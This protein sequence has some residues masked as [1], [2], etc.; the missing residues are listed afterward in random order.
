MSVLT[1]R[2]EGDIAIA[3]LDN[4][5]VNALSLEVR[6]A[7]WD[8]VEELDADPGV[9]A[10]I[11]ACAGR[12]FIAGADVKEFGKPP[13]P[14]HLPDLVARIEA[15][16]TPWIAAIHGSALGGGLEIAMGCRFRIAH[17]SA[18]VG[19]PEVNLGIIP[20][21]S[22]TVRTPRLM[23]AKAAVELVT[24]GRPISA[25]KAEKA[26]LVDA[27]VAGDLEE[28]ALVFAR[29]ALE[30]PLPPRTSERQVEPQPD[31]FWQDAAKT[32]SKAGHQA[33]VRAV[34]CLRRATEASFDEAMAHERETFLELRSAPEAA[35]L[36]HV[37]FAERAAPRPAHLKGVEPSDIASAGVVGG[38]TMG[39]GIAT[40]LGL[41]GLPVTVMETSDEGAERAKTRILGNF[42]G[43]LKR[44]KIDAAERERLGDAL[45]VTTD[46]SDLSS[47]DLVVEAVFE[48]LEVKRDVFARLAAAC[49]D[50]TILATNT[51]YLDPRE[52]FAGL[53]GQGRCIGLHFFSPAHVMKLVEIVP[54]PGTTPETEA[55]AFKLCARLG[56]MPVRAGICDGFIGNR[57]LKRYRAEAE[58]L[59]E[60]GV[61][62]AE[63]D[64][65]MRGFG[66]KMGPFEAQDLGGLDIAAAQRNAAREAGEDVPETLGDLLV[67]AGRK[68]QKS[69]GG[70]YDYAEGDRTPQPSGKVSE[71]LSSRVRGTSDL[72]REDIAARL[73]D[74]MAR[75][76]EAILSEGIA[77]RSA[78]IDLVEIHGYGFPRRTGG[79]MHHSGRS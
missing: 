73:V 79:P 9:R 70:W 24:S 61:P 43:A 7:L 68:G 20:G 30:R 75:E 17:E 47:C 31:S 15:S 4:P 52:I 19:L 74:A 48:D 36:R 37:F 13:E 58:A 35:A 76:G 2:R 14:P 65:A 39:A 38:G 6:Q 26:G 54:L 45:K 21:A 62:I 27:V 71:L 22:G 56:K 10:V 78:D 51:S 55:A 3:T 25:A 23:G 77:S 32:A 33:P 11:L 41:A 67:A 46:V 18:K 69:R 63:V 44:G 8:A 1:I 59:V 66:M 12:T 64:A 16:E 34:D 28:E 57:I 60:Q 72:P 50:R 42:D 5:P 53:E 40:A 29:S 49:G